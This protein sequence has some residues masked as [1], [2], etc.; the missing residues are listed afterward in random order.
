MAWVCYLGFKTQVALAQRFSQARKGLLGLL[1][2]HCDLHWRNLLV[3]H[4]EI[5]SSM[6]AVP[7][8]QWMGSLLDLIMNR[9]PYFSELGHVAG[10]LTSRAN[11]LQGKIQVQ[12]RC[13]L[14]H[15]LMTAGTALLR[16]FSEARNA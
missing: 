16:N 13:G 1:R 10:P 12:C 14:L 9:L 11:M 6:C 4:P 15:H 7:S 3:N 2:H 5:A 8:R